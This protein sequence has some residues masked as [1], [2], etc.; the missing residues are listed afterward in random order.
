MSDERRSP[1]EASGAPAAE[2]D[3]YDGLHRHRTQIRMP[4]HRGDG[5]TY[6]LDFPSEELARIVSRQIRDGIDAQHFN[7]RVAALLRD[8]RVNDKDGRC[9][10]CKPELSPGGESLAHA[11][12]CELAALL[13]AAE[14]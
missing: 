6:G 2:V 10:F 13:A 9:Q 5:S 8:S 4:A 11:P 12:G 3:P 7:R 14:S 1:T